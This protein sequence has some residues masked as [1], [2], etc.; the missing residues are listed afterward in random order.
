MS[1][2]FTFKHQTT[3]HLGEEFSSYLH[4]EMNFEVNAL[5]NALRKKKKIN[6]D[7]TNKTG[8]Y[9]DTLKVRFRVNMQRL[10]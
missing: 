4:S 8:W 7:T 1:Q 5:S 3:K 10:S 9:E 6:K 2:C